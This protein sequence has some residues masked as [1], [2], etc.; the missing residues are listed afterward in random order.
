MFFM[1]RAASIGI[2]ACDRFLIDHGTWWC[3]R[4]ST[5]PRWGRVH[6]RG[7]CSRSIDG[8]EIGAT[9]WR[10]VQ[11][12]HG[13]TCRLNRWLR[14]TF[15]PSTESTICG[16]WGWWCRGSQRQSVCHESSI[17]FWGP[18]AGVEFGEAVQLAIWSIFNFQ[19]VGV[20]ALACGYTPT[21]SSRK[22]CSGRATKSCYEQLQNLL[23]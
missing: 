13:V 14:P 10:T 16:G 20:Y 19:G 6:T 17:T 5:S 7:G 15:K 1:F 12:S 23:S 21:T 11:N 18:L 9:F 8:G 3:S 4:W 22:G 2:K